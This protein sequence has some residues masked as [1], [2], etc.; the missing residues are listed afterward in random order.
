[1]KCDVCDRTSSTTLHGFTLCRGHG[2]DLVT[3]VM[4]DDA[5]PLGAFMALTPVPSPDP[6]PSPVRLVNTGAP[7]DRHTYAVPVPGARRQAAPTRVT[8][9]TWVNAFTHHATDPNKTWPTR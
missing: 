7:L 1:M 6:A 4:V 5:T 2:R 8:A 9:R 3:A